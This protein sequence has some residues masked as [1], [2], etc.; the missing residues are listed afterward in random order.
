MILPKEVRTILRIWEVIWLPVPVDG[1]AGGVKV[2]LLAGDAVNVDDPAPMLDLEEV[3]NEDPVGRTE[4]VEEDLAGCTDAL[5]VKV[6][7]VV[8]LGVIGAG[9]IGAVLVAILVAVVLV[10]VLSAPEGEEDAEG[11][12]DEDTQGGQV[13][14]HPVSP[15]VRI[16]K[17]KGWGDAHLQKP[18][19]VTRYFPRWQTIHSGR[20]L[21]V[22]RKTTAPK[23]RCWGLRNSR[24]H[25]GFH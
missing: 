5:E 6:T 9:V 8:W 15:L 25:D 22:S 4:A 23:A 21:S 2:E 16:D 1:G 11:D 19:G 17:N 18:R 12:G 7:R 24:F 13:C 3:L 10:R 14:Y 20:Y